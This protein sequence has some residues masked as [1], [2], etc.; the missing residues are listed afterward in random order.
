MRPAGVASEQKIPRRLSRWKEAEKLRLAV[1]TS[2]E[3][4]CNLVFSN[5][6]VVTSTVAV[7]PCPLCSA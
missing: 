5:V 1:G 6:A 7:V 3:F 2:L 4:I